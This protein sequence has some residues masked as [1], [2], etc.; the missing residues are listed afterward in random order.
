MENNNIKESAAKSF[1]FIR[2]LL[3]M[4]FQ[5][6]CTFECITTQIFQDKGN[7]Q[8]TNHLVESESIWLPQKILYMGNT[9]L[10]IKVMNL[11]YFLRE[12]EVDIKKKTQRHHN[13]F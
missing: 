10:W 9:A 2:S 11:F 7:Q 12:R 13:M 5:S 8:Q 1:A 3:N 6:L 4:A